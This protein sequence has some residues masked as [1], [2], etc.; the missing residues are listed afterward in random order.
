M[1]QLRNFL[2]ITASALCIFACSSCVSGQDESAYLDDFRIGVIE[3]TGQENKTSISL[4]NESLDLVTSLDYKLGS[5]GSFFC[6][7]QKKDNKVYV[8]PEGIST[9]SDLTVVFC[10]DLTKGTTEEIDIGLRGA[11]A[12]FVNDDYIFSSVSWN[13]ETSLSRTS[14][15]DHKTDHTS[16][17]SVFFVNQIYTYNNRLFLLCMTSTDSGSLGSRLIE[18]DTESLALINETDFSEFGVSF[19]NITHYKETL[20]FGSVHRWSDMLEVD[21]QRLV[22]YDLSTNSVA[23]IDLAMKYPAQLALEKASLYILHASLPTQES[24]GISVFNLD[25]HRLV[26]YELSHEAFQIIVKDNMLYSLGNT[27][28][29]TYDLSDDKLTF[30]SE[31]Y[32]KQRTE[33]QPYYYVSSMFVN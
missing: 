1:K 10:I 22:L 26:Y 5:M 15:L 8:V 19:S 12:F 32:V 16:L 6:L 4:Y 9:L 7:P 3:T 30:V 23:T 29:Y 11:T 27:S 13:G 24:F 33:K 2:L 18:L 14:L 17:D 20:V 31:A 25:T 21:D 28:L